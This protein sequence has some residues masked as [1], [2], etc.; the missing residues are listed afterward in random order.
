MKLI[1]LQK[2]FEIPFKPNDTEGIVKT[3]SRKLSY[4]TIPHQIKNQD[5]SVQENSPNCNN[6]EVTLENFYK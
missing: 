1:G 6:T 3:I 4:N 5:S 2:N